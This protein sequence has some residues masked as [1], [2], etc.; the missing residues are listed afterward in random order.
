MP[1]SLQLRVT[2]GG[3]LPVIG[4]SLFGFGLIW[5][6]FFLRISEPRFGDPFAGQVTTVQGRVV[7]V[8]ATGARLNESTVFAVHFE[9]PADDRK[10]LA[11]SYTTHAVP[12][13][14]ANVLV[15]YVPL[16]PPAV[17]IR[18]MR[19]ALF[20]AATG[21]AMIVPA[22]GLVVLM[23]GALRGL[24]SMRLLRDGQLTRGRLV[25]S[26]PTHTRINGL[27]VYRL[28]FRYVDDAKNE[29]EGTV[30]THRLPLVTDEQE[31]LLLYE[32]GGARILLW[33][34]L[35]G[36]PKVD[37]NGQF[38]PLGLGAL[39]PLWLPPTVIA[40]VWAALQPFLGLLGR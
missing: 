20:P 17:R 33:D 3:V 24:R 37:R 12:N 40:V 38:L 2:F 18:G 23:L 7:K 13:V 30:R 15:D 22:A 14:D 36:R 35:P 11:V 19:T 21:F 4:W 39:V 25:D 1:L 8:E 28:T 10:Q 31:E 27:R 32:P 9:Y 29:R 16:Q 34:L 5:I 26:Q 6:A